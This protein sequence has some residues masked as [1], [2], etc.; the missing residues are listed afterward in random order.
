MPTLVQLLASS[1]VSDVQESVAMLLTCK[2]FEVAGAPEAIR[3]MLPLIFARDQGETLVHAS[4]SVTRQFE[5]IYL[6]IYLFR[7]SHRIAS[8]T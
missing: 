5:T 1:T 7:T 4:R 8:F 2:Q 6:L 3:K